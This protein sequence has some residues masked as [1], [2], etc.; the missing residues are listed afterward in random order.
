MSHFD[1]D[2]NDTRLSD[3]IPPLF[4]LSDLSDNEAM[5]KWQNHAYDLELRKAAKYRMQA[6][7]H[8]QLFEGKFYAS[9][10][11]RGGTAEMSMA[12]IGANVPKVSKLVVNHLYDLVIQRVSRLT[13]NKP[14]VSINPAN[15]E[16]SD[17]ISAK[18][19][20]YLV[21]Y[22]MYQN[23]FDTLMIELAQSAYIDGESYLKIA[24]DP[25][26]GHMHPDWKE[27]AAE[28]RSQRR[29][30]RLPVLDENGEQV[31][32]EKGDPLFIER[33]IY[34]GDVCL[35]VW[36]PVDTLVQ[37]CGD[38]RKAK[39]YIHEEWMDADELKALYP[40]HAALFVPDTGD[41]TGFGSE[42]NVF[43]PESGP[44]SGKILVRKFWHK[45]DQFLASGREVW[46]TRKVVLEN[47]PL[48][49]G[50]TSL[51]LVRFSD[52]DIKDKQ[53][54]QSFFIHGK[55]IN[56]TINDLTSM[57]R[58]NSL[59][60][61]HP[62]WLIPRGSV[63]KKDSLSNE[64]AQIEYQGSVPPQLVA[65]PPMSQ[66]I[67]MLRKDLKQDLQTIL[68]V[69][70]ISR[71]QVPANIRS[72]LALQVMDEQEDQRANSSVSKHAST[73]R[74]VVQEIIEVASAHYHKDDK[75]LIPVVGRD[76]RYMLKEFDPEHLSRA[77]D[78]RVSNASG[79]PT[80]KA[81][82]TETLVEL[83]KAFPTLVRDEQVA[84]LLQWGESERFYDI[85]TVAVR[86]AE[87]ENES[88][89]N[90]EETDEPTPF[91]D[92]ITH[93]TT[94]IREVQNRGF[95]T[96]TPPEIQAALIS[97]ILGT[98]L[99]MMEQARKTPSFA[100]ELVQLKQFPV[101]YA[102]DAID[103]AVLDAAR[104]GNP[105]NYAQLRALEE[106]GSLEAMAG[107]GAPPPPGGVPN[108]SAPGG[109][110]MTQGVVPPPN[111]AM[112]PPPPEVGNPLPPNAAGEP[113]TY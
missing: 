110:P 64:I 108:P 12:G 91:E 30:P 37:A 7:K 18:I 1:T 88:L 2:F 76:N 112:P 69:F 9:N 68:G 98:E 29:E 113:Q 61:A 53:K 81:A 32:S 102:I 73:I 74:E 60:L 38:H 13:R 3:R 51:G 23:N 99:L 70:D 107:L 62:K 40:E 97:H 27:E 90:G 25:N 80:S 17:R 71:G 43:A 19:V 28:A 55:A 67:N 20:K 87:A 42:G 109:A 89:L 47:K 36:T 4:T 59:M 101:F 57:T 96:N 106:S 94:H 105:L 93:W 100:L 77:Y 65:P 24:W 41:V 46:S 34:V 92:H 52:I 11:G 44:E 15:S 85:A 75:R 63:V 111:G 54:G 39:Y 35:S 58:R 104:T 21:D 72:A 16:Y 5:L 84:D 86:S 103:R 79:L 31:V 48:A 45:P 49:S 10:A 78:V 56:A 22:I 8:R 83:K 95:K 50:L 82:R 14:A 66:E 33:P 6:L 26:R